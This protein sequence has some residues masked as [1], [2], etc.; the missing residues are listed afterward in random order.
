MKEILET[1]YRRKVTQKDIDDLSKEERNRIISDNVV[2]ST[3]HF[4]KRIDKLFSLMKYDF[5]H[6]SNETYHASSYFYRIEFQQRGA[7]HVHSLVWLKN[8]SNKDAPNF[9][10]EGEEEKTKSEEN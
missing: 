7:P 5:F 9:W 2:Q 8:E 3:I 10:A 1:V 4:Q 6:G